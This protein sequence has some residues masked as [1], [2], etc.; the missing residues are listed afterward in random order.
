VSAKILDGKKLAAEIQQELAEEVAEF[1]GSG[2]AV[3]KLA[4][5]LSAGGH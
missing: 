3:P 5:G 2:N 1:V 4:A